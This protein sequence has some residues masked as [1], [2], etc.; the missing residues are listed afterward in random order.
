MRAWRRIDVRPFQRWDHRAR[1]W[2]LEWDLVTAQYPEWWRS[3]QSQF[4]HRQRCKHCI[5]RL[6]FEQDGWSPWRSNPEW[7]LVRRRCRSCSGDQY[8]HARW[9]TSHHWSRRT[10]WPWQHLQ[11]RSWRMVWYGSILWSFPSCPRAHSEEPFSYQAPPWISRWLHQ[12][13]F[14]GLR[15]PSGALT[16]QQSPPW[17][18]R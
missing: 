5:H 8:V 1:W 12:E 11:P 10:S 9:G 16:S 6:R 2:I 7:T 15:S 13:P 3:F 18:S 4:D 14:A 17:P